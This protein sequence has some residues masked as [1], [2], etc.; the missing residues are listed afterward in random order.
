MDNSKLKN[1]AQELKN[2]A[3]K[4]C[5]KGWIKS[6]DNLTNPIDD[7]LECFDEGFISLKLKER[8]IEEVKEIIDQKKII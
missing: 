5:T 1:K 7:I 6:H 3:C 4:E 8:L 2:L